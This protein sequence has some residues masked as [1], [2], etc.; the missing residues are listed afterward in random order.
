MFS[1]EL[2]RKMQKYFQ[3]KKKFHIS[4]TRLKPTGLRA[5]SPVFFFLGESLNAGMLL[6]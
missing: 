1:E 2:S 3:M 5:S 6:C 4:V